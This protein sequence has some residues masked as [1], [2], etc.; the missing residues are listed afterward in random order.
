MNILL[1]GQSKILNQKLVFKYGK[2][3]S[4]KKVRSS[5]KKPNYKS[6]TNE[7]KEKTTSDISPS[8]LLNDFINYSP[9]TFNEKHI[10]KTDQNMTC[11]VSNNK[12]LSK[13]KAVA[14]AKQFLEDY[15]NFLN[16]GYDTIY[17]N[18]TLY[19]NNMIIK[20]RSNL[21]NITNYNK[22]RD[23]YTKYKVSFKNPNNKNLATNIPKLI[24]FNINLFNVKNY[25]CLGILPDR[26]IIQNHKAVS[27]S[28]DIFLNN[29]ME[30]SET[31]KTDVIALK[32]NANF[33][34][35]DH[36]SVPMCL[37]SQY[38]I[39]IIPSKEITLNI[40]I[41][42]EINDKIQN[43]E[44][45]LT[46]FDLKLE[47]VIFKLNLK[48]I[49]KLHELS[50]DSQEVGDKFLKVGKYLEKESL[51]NFKHEFKIID[52]CDLMKGNK[53]I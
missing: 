4:T 24:N 6:E 32:E 5:L 13:I 52:V 27:H 31:I 16:K 17:E 41:T 1:N 7:S 8:E 35:K 20:L 40:E 26:K 11:F 48:D 34:T 19:E 49:Q 42:D 21:E 25:I 22:N 10:V 50:Q 9:F 43:Y 33:T 18:S 14:M 29:P 36:E 45:G 28:Y 53:L 51:Q 39:Q 44:F 23:S 30:E 47:S 3:M 46:S 2:K 38:E 37:L 12:I 15:I